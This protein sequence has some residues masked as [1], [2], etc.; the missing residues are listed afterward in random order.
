VLPAWALGD[1]APQP[2]VIALRGSRLDTG[3]IARIV[4]HTVPGARI[5][6]RSRLLDAI[7]AAPLAHGGFVTLAQGAAAAAAFSLLILLFM[8]L[9]SARA[10]ALTL[11]RLDAMGLSPAQSRRITMVESLPVILSAVLGGSASAVAL[12]P[13][14]GSAVD[15][16]AFT[17]SQ[18]RVPLHTDPL[19]LGAVTGG[20]LLL[21]GVALMIQDRLARREDVSQALR[22]G[23]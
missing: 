16:A 21:A 6:L 2:T 8:M 17:G 22:A 23:D 4:R 20:L 1:R 9:L 11:A 5:T 7:A 18:V 15:L 10:R 19:A 3:A 13:L 14:A 12:V